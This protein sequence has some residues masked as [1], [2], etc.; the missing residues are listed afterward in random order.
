MVCDCSKQVNY[1]IIDVMLKKQIL[2]VNCTIQDLS[3][4]LGFF[5]VL[6]VSSCLK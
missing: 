5:F 4:L 6:V 2:I 3:L 1:K